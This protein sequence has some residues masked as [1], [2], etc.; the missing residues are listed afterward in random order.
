MCPIHFFHKLQ[1]YVALSH[2]TVVHCFVTNHNCLLSQITAICCFV[3]N[4][5]CPLFWDKLE[6]SIVASHIIAVHCFVTIAVHSFITDFRC[7]LYLNGVTLQYVNSYG[8]LGMFTH[9]HRSPFTT[10]SDNTS[11][12]VDARL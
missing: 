5:S 4:Y 3:A 12:V 9:Y 10:R 11:P 6:L 2:N 8:C 1:L 7:S